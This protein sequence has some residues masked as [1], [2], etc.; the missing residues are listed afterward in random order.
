MSETVVANPLGRHRVKVV[1]SPPAGGVSNIQRVSN[2][3]NNNNAIFPPPPLAISSNDTWIDSHVPNDSYVYTVV[4]NDGSHASSPS[5]PVRST[6]NSTDSIMIDL[7]THERSFGSFDFLVP[8]TSI[9]LEYLHAPGDITD[10]GATWA[11]TNQLPLPANM[12]IQDTSL[13]LVQSLD[14]T[15]IAIVRAAPTDGSNSGILLGYEFKGTSW[16]G[17]T[18]LQA[19]N[20]SD[21]GNNGGGDNGS[22]RD[23]RSASNSPDHAQSHSVRLDNVTASQALIESDGGGRNY[24]ELL[25][26]RGGEIFH[27]TY[28]AHSGI[29]Q[30]GQL[31]AKF[32]PLPQGSQFAAVS[33]VQST[34]G[35]LVAITLVTPANTLAGYVFGQGSDNDS[36]DD[37]DGHDNDND[38]DGHG[39]HGQRGWQPFTIRSD[40]GPITGVTGSPEFIQSSGTTFDL[41]V[42]QGAVLNHYRFTGQDV[43]QGVWHLNATLP[44]ASY[45]PQAQPI[46]LALSLNVFGNLELTARERP[47]Q[48]TGFDFMAGYVFQLAGTQGQGQWS[49]GVPLRDQNGNVIVATDGSTSTIDDGPP[50]PPSQPPTPPP[51]NPPP[52]TPPPPIF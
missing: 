30:P 46:A 39:N 35:E 52:S 43:R 51:S 31:V 7:E 25:V 10:N 32:P 24:F 6:S 22:N 37:H 16:S 34:T 44:P 19:K 47:P 1:W 48:G 42:P 8:L 38:D 49:S 15:L 45:N 3:N 9:I 29:D 17:P 2:D 40:Q 50:P 26:P 11:Q 27:Y 36:D 4:F 23:A 12:V 14:G 20:H 21:D 13:S 33:L 18:Y 5:V 28:D 41:I